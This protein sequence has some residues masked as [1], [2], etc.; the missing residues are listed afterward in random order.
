LK[1]EKMKKLI[2]FLIVITFVIT[3]CGK[4]EE[5]TKEKTSPQQSEQSTIQQ[6]KEDSLK[7]VKDQTDREKKVKE[8]LE[9]EKILKDSLGQWAVSAEAS[10]TYGD[11]TGKDSWTADQMIGAP[12]VDTYGDNGKAWTSKE[13]EK[14]VEWVILNYEKPVNA[15]EVRIRQTFNPGAIIKVELI[16]TKGKSHA[17][18][19]GLDKTK[20]DAVTI[21][22]FKAKFDK[23]DY[24]TKTVKITLATNSIPGWKEIDAV[25]LLGE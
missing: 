14:G 2:Y 25:Q 13:Q 7:A 20:Y 6:K 1:A 23:T 17:V 5:A 9:E 19:E 22:Y 10:S 18:W 3:S 12:D 16:D 11:H 4:K 15:T 21:Q 24:K 8:A